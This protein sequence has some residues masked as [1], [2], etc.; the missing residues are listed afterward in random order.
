MRGTL[1]INMGVFIQNDWSIYH[2][3]IDESIMFTTNIRRFLS[4]QKTTK[5][6]N[7][8]PGA[9]EDMFIDQRQL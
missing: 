3:I 9:P 8:K 5:F 4:M 7:Y 2:S 6:V 1:A